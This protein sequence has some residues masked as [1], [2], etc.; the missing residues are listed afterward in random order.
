MTG[1]GHVFIHLTSIQNIINFSFSCTIIAKTTAYFCQRVCFLLF[2]MLKRCNV[3][4][5]SD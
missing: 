5:L 3:T 1:A 2:A 4:A